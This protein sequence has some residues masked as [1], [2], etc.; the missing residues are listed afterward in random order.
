V[1]R[2]VCRYNA[3]EARSEWGRGPPRNLR[4]R[5]KG[6]VERREWRKLDYWMDLLDGWTFCM[7]LLVGPSGW[8]YWLDLPNGP[9][10][11]LDGSTDWTDWIDRLCGSRWRGRG[12]FVRGKFRGL[13]QTSIKT[14][15][16]D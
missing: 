1:G 6:D 13:G 12:C 7:D 10:D 3:D 14:P 5:L 16:D 11:P 4:Y 8:P 2:N 9:M 15:L